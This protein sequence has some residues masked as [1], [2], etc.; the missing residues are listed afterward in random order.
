MQ[1]KNGLFLTGMYVNRY[2]RST[3][4]EMCTVSVVNVN[5]Y[6][7]ADPDFIVRGPQRMNGGKGC[8]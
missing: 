2:M 3:F 7:N 4:A 1:L 5:V 6:S 8:E